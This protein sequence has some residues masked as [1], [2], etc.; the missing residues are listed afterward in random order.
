MKT[1]INPAIIKEAKFPHELSMVNLAAFNLL[2]AP[3]AIVLNIGLLGLLIPLL[4]SCSMIL[5]IWLKAKSKQKTVHWFIAAHWDLA[6]RR[7]KIL[8]IGYSISAIILG[9]ATLALAHSKMEH[10]MMVAFT[11]VA[12]VPTLICVMISFVMVS[13]G[14]FQ[15]SKSEIPDSIAEKFTPNT[16]T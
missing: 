11:R 16:T 6:R 4:L 12:I 3:A 13:G 9:F 5:F 10:I 15:A 2:A 14:L 1:D 7:T 8:L